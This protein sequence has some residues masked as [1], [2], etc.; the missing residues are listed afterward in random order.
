M[1]SHKAGESRLD[2]LFY[3]SSMSFLSKI[4][5]GNWFHYVMLSNLSA[6]IKSV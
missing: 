3:K 1:N 4:A 6:K 5:S 2:I